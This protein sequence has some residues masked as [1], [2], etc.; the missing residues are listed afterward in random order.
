M[1]LLNVA[2]VIAYG[3]A[4]AA[5]V[6]AL[7]SG[8]LLASLA[9]EVVGQKLA[10]VKKLVQLFAERDPSLLRGARESCL[11]I[12][13]TAGE[14]GDMALIEQVPEACTALL[15]HEAKAAWPQA[16]PV[17]AGVFDALG[18]IRANVSPADILPWTRARFERSRAL[19][20]TLMEI[21]DKSH[22]GELNVFGKEL[23]A[24]LGSAVKAFGP[25]AVL[26]VAGL[27]LLEVPLNEK[28]YEQASRS[29]LLLVLRDSCRRTWLAFFASFFMPLAS[30][31]R[32]KA[33][34]AE[35]A[36]S[37]LFAKKYLTLLEHVWALLPAFCDE[38]LDLSAAFMAEG[39]RLAKQLVSVLQKEPQLRD[40]VWMAFTRL[41]AVAQE[42]P[43]PLS[44]ALQESNVACLR[45]LAARVLPEMFGAYLKLHAEGEEQDA[46][47][48]GHSR[49]LALEAVQ[50]YAKVAEPSLVGSLFKNIVARW[51]KATAGEADAPE[52]AEAKPVADLANALIPHLPPDCLELALKVYTPALKGAVS[53]SEDDEGSVASLQKAAYRV[54]CSVLQHPAAGAGNG[55]SDVSK[56]FELWAVLRDARQTCAAPSLKARLTAIEALLNLMERHLGPQF[57]NPAVRQE[58]MQCLTTILPEVLFHLRDQGTGVR[59][60]ARECLRVAATTAVHQEMLAEVVALLSAGLAGLT[61]HSKASAVDALSRLLYETRSKMDRQLRDR[62]IMVVLL[63]LGDDDAQVWRA[64]LKFTKVVVY[65]VPKDGLPAFLPQILKLFD[66]R[67]VAS[68]K[69]LIRHIIDRLVKVVPAETLNEVFPKAHLPLLTY[70]QRQHAREGRPKVVLA[71]ADGGEGDGNDGE[72]DAEM[73]DDDGPKESWA[74]FQQG[75]DA[76]EEAGDEDEGK[77][78]RPGKKRARGSGGGG[79]EPPMS[80]VMAHDS[81]QALL[82]AWEAESDGSDDG[83]GGARRRSKATKGKRKHDAVETTTW[84]H[85]DKDVPLDFMSADAA[86]SVLTVRPPQQK[87]RR[88]SITGAA[89]AQN[90][91]EALRRSGLCFAEDGRLVVNEEAEEKGDKEEEEGAEAKKLFAGGAGADAKKPKA[92]SRL[93]EQRKARLAAKGK[94]KLQRRG[95]HQIKGLDSTKPGKKGSGDGKRK[96]STLKPYAYVQLNPKVTKEKYRDRA[97][98]TFESVVQG[99]KKGVLKGTKAKARDAK[100]KESKVAKKNKQKANRKAHKP[101]GSR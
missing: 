71:A 55:P 25:E 82:N 34:E 42:P 35:S 33:V 100:L 2:Y 37:P 66:S 46:S 89:G 85:E 93:A 8:R 16:L 91:A 20:A 24:C 72:D 75:D 97:S 54:V 74:T 83:E 45:K 79:A 60:A 39:G 7:T 31:L 3:K 15:S 90:R 5:A 21:R 56:I 70:I 32:T 53:A 73:G 28:Y 78:P 48:A 87:R 65:V 59:D 40:Y 14:G 12:L 10:A 88:G 9:P 6:A 51:L 58:F 19:I 84:I 36:A 52:A 61:R 22:G 63:L 98:K 76:G 64:V 29:W 11:R 23:A 50:G 96:G 101:T 44:Q 94:A 80:A 30:A 99:A 49:H 57:T 43:S 1:T 38:P 95:V 86:H 68:A 18:A 47:R 69:M 26:S 4:L 92:L 13:K 67:H 62:L 41:C 77:A 81:V 17:V 27:K